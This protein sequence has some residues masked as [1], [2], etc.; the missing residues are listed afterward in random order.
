[1]P[2]FVGEQQ[3][4]CRAA[5]VDLRTI[6]IVETASMNGVIFAATNKTRVMRA[7]IAAQAIGALAQIFANFDHWGE[8]RTTILITREHF[9]R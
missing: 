8:R 9:E 6:E 4:A 5:D 1:M 3:T 7:E 2:N